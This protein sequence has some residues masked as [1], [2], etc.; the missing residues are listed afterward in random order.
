M[1]VFLCATD[2]VADQ[3]VLYAADA[4]REGLR[5]VRAD[6]HAKV[7]PDEAVGIERWTGPL[8]FWRNRPGAVVEVCVGPA[9][10]AVGIVAEV[11]P[12][13]WS[14]RSTRR[15]RACRMHS[16]QHFRGE[17]NRNIPKRCPATFLL[18]YSPIPPRSE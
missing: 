7:N 8:V 15:L 13:S 11:I 12:D 3:G 18:K 9:L 14:G 2:F 16:G 1:A 10:T 5:R 17:D 6:R 4:K